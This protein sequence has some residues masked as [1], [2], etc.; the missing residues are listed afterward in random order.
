MLES[1]YASTNKGGRG[2]NIEKKNGDI[3]SATLSK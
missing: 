1:T 2:A 3:V